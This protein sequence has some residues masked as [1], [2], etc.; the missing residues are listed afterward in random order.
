VIVD[1]IELGAVSTLWFHSSRISQRPHRHPQVPAAQVLKEAA[2][3][4]DRFAIEFLV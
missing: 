4:I 3:G 1:G 2:P